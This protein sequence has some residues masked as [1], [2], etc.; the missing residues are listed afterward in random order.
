MDLWGTFS[1]WEVINYDGAFF[2]AEGGNA[3]AFIEKTGVLSKQA[4]QNLSHGHGFTPKGTIDSKSLTGEIGVT[5]RYILPA[6]GIFS[7]G[8]AAKYW[9]VSGGDAGPT[10]RDVRIDASHAHNFVGTADSTDYSGGSECRP[11]NY[12]IR[13]WKRTA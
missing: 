10:D 5:A 12:T 7:Y 8:S 6:S 1:T 13:V 11:D 2:R 4:G 3:D 9:S